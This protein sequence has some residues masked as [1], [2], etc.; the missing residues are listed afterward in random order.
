MLRTH[1]QLTRDLGD[2]WSEADTLSRLGDT[3][4]ALGDPTSARADWHRALDI[5]TALNHPDAATVRAKLQ[6]P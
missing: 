6:L 4:D 5:F 3:R 1:T 2:R